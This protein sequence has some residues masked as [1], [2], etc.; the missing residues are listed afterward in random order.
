MT[1]PAAT[2]PPSVLLTE[3]DPVMEAAEPAAVPG[4]RTAMAAPLR[5]LVAGGL[6][7]AL[8]VGLWW[9]VWTGS[10]SGVMTCDCTD[11][12]RTVWYLEWSAFALTH[13]HGLLHSNWLF[14]PAGL[15]LLADTS[16][17]ALALLASPVTLAFG[18]VTAMNVAST[19]VPVL[20]ALSM[21]WLLQRWVRWQP[22]AFL[23]GL[24]YGFSAAV[25]VQLAF[26]WLNLAFLALIP[27]MAACLD[28]LLVRQRRGPVRIGIAL[29]VLVTAE[30]FVSTEAVLILAVSGT[31][32]VALL[33]GFAALRH[34]EE[35]GRRWRHACTGLVSALAA[36]AVLLAYP[37]W[38][39]VAGPAHLDGMVW[40]TNVPGN[41]GN[42]VSN[43]WSQSGQWGPVSSRF[44][45]GEAPLLGG[46]RGPGLPAAS[47]LGTGLLAVIV[48]GMLVWRSDRRLW[49][50]GALGLTTIVISLRAGGGQ[51]GPWALVDHLPLFDNVVQS[52][53][54]AVFG[55]CAAVMLA[56]IVDRTRSSVLTRRR[57]EPR[58]IDEQRGARAARWGATVAALAVTA[59]AVVPVVSTLGPNLPLRTQPVTVPRWFLTTGEHL[60]PRQVLL[61]YP[62][63]TAD[64]QSA[65]PWQAIGGMHYTMAGGG[66]PAGTAARAGDARPDS[67]YWI[68]RRCHWVRPP[69]PT[70][71]NLRAIRDAMRMWGVTMVVVPDDTGLAQFQ[72]ARGAAFG[73]AFLAAV[74]GSVPVSQD[75]AWVWSH[76]G[77]SPAPVPVTTARF[78]ACVSA[79]GAAANGP[80]QA[81]RCVVRQPDQTPG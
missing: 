39:F 62:F 51:W 38:F 35:L 7:L 75:G 31:V 64:S 63:A 8:S 53:F 41:L 25:I 5:M 42:A 26:G 40:S 78:G 46:Y 15:N 49:F 68:R 18:P 70:G 14:P 28:E 81:A 9:H 4:A 21:Y 36:A 45:A 43:L 1:G 13:G 37:V 32:A 66:G 22:A 16:V 48:V 74:L 73:V 50:F 12:G 55:L 19:L 27:L 10:P 77:H 60:S 24:V 59:V 47:Y 29:A 69:A 20:T 11:A 72:T 56:V 76:V 6:Y 52:R 34:P 33:T 57:G 17:P 30:F 54:D 79:A 23:G 58:G 44:L 61:T 71:P 67:R 80:E 3:P 2:D 65:L